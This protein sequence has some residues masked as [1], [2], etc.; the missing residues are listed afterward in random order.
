MKDGSF[1]IKRGLLSWWTCVRTEEAW[2]LSNRGSRCERLAGGLPGGLGVR[3]GGLV[4][5]PAFVLRNA[6]LLEDPGGP[7]RG[8]RG[9][10]NLRSAAR[11][12]LTGTAG[13][14]GESRAGLWWLPS[15]GWHCGRSR[16]RPP[17][18]GP[19]HGDAR[20]RVCS[21][22]TCAEPTENRC[23]ECPAGSNS[24]VHPK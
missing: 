18:V 24:G 6:F 10:F 9:L 23:E 12:A 2:T 1:R 19:E 3:P 5:S 4:C 7:L 15:Q 8:R 13:A 21:S 17:A 22:K 16:P 14:S 11:S 20:N